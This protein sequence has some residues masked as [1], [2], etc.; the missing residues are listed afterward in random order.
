MARKKE[1]V[2][3]VVQCEGDPHLVPKLPGEWIESLR[4]AGLLVNHPVDQ[5]GITRECF[6]IRPPHGANSKAWAEMNA[7]RMKSFSINAAAA[8]SIE[9]PT[10]AEE[11]EGFTREPTLIEQ[12][13][14][15]RRSLHLGTEPRGR[16][17]V[18][19]DG[20]YGEC[21]FGEMK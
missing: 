9:E 14:P 4:Y 10:F 12:Y 11:T 15:C 17:C 1:W 20:H 3:R 6:D 8:P 16:Q 2:V 7:K 5:R 19:S 18:L 13:G 21:I